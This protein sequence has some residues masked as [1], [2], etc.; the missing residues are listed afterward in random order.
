M[1]IYDSQKLCNNRRFSSSLVST[2]FKQAG[3]KP[4]FSFALF[5]QKKVVIS[6]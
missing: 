1:I 3:P 6:L 4:K 2:A 5:E